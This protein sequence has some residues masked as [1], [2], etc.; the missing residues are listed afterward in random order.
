MGNGIKWTEEEKEYLKSIVKGRHYKEIAELMNNKF[1]REFNVYIIK[2]AI[3]R[4]KLNTGFNGQFKK[5]NIPFNKGQKG[6]C[7]KGCEKT[8]F[9]KGNIPKNH[10][11]VGSERKTKDG[12]IMVKVAEPSKWRLKHV[13]EW[14]KVN[15]KLPEGHALI[16][17]DRNKENTS[18]DNLRLV[19]RSELLII[20]SNNLLK[21]SKEINETVVNIAK[22]TDKVR[23]IKS[24]RRNND[25][26]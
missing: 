7:G 4:Y 13:V 15:G 5:G 23:K 14:E 18:L 8:W 3:S 24:S 25:N 26:S 20:N 11:P 22:V 2:N 16:F 21:N 6:M 10:K 12:Y 19:S 9:K 1:E 17:L